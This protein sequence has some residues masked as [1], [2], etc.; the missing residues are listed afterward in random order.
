[1]GTFNF[2]D[3]EIWS[4]IITISV[5]IGAMLLANILRRKI[6]F[7]R[8]SLLP[9]AVLGGFIVLIIESVY[10]KITG[11]SM[12]EANTLESLTYHGLG[13][14]FIALAWRHLDGVKG[15]KARRDVFHTSTVTVGGYLIQA[16][17][18]LI[19]TAVLFYLIGSFAAGGIILPMG[20]GQG[21]GQAFNWG[22][23]YENGYGFINGSSFG[24]TVAAMGFVSA[25]AGGLFYLNRPE[26][27]GKLRKDGEE[28]RDDLKAEDYC[29]ENE[30]PVSES[31]DKLTVQFGLVFLTY[32]VAF[33]SMWLLYK[34]VLLPAGGFALNTINPLIWGFNFLVGTAWA[35]L[36]KNIGNKLR[37][38]GVM[39]REYTNNFMLNR[40]SGLMFDLMVVASIASID[41]SAFRY[42]EF[43]LPLLLICVA[44][45]LVTYW[46]C[47][48]LCRHLF[49]DYSDEM[50]LVMFGMLTGTASTGVILLREIDPLFK[51]PASHNLIY[52]NLWSIVLGA[53]ML[54]MMGFVPRSMTHQFVCMGIILL[55]FCILLVVQ[56]RDVSF[57][58]KEKAE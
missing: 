31:L 8:R 30:I 14:G 26:L 40:I 44:G 4:F 57:R 58:K 51:T 3:V 35:I 39:H 45:A 11:S 20:Y 22:V 10:K 9:S 16:L 2:W 50:F 36:F 47:R 34:Y 19:I 12:F 18:G 37:A 1:M 52:Q 15:K 6:P 41:L 29:G 23:N 7:L 48:R 13:L 21:P 42:K 53:P 32:A 24:L 5:L 56:Y 46:Y 27:K 33:L 25:C 55:L 28:I 54:L 43:W 49:P 38:K 17:V